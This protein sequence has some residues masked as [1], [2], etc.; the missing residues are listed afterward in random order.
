[1]GA[2]AEEWRRHK[3]P[4]APC[5]GSGDYWGKVAGNILTFGFVDPLP[6]TLA[7]SHA[8]AEQVN[9]VCEDYYRP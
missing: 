9:S 7:H 2:T 1:M 6:A 5:A 3:K 8:A 4:P